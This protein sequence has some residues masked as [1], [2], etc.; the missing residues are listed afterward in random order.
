MSL[1]LSSLSPLLKPRSSAGEEGIMIANIFRPF[2]SSGVKRGGRV[3]VHPLLPFLII[4]SCPRGANKAAGSIKGGIYTA[5][6]AAAERMI[7]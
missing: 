5:A 2:L 1:T 3:P 6:I 7:L 4:Y